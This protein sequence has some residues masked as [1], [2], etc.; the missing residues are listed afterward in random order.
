MNS[1]YCCCP[2]QVDRTNYYDACVKDTC[3]CNS[4]GDCECF[5][6]AVEAYAAACNR[7]G[8][9]VRW[10]SPSICRESPCS[11]T[12]NVAILACRDE[13]LSC[14]QH[15]LLSTPTHISLL[16]AD[17]HLQQT[18]ATT[19]PPGEACGRKAEACSGANDKWC[20]FSHLKIAPMQLRY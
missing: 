6:S 7:A 13:A 8:A 9:C 12:K 17:F 3:A 15:N 14:I 1:L 2:A 5:C 20:Y 18:G 4:G 19:L 16:V 11:H 10:R